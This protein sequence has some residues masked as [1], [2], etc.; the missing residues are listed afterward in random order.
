MANF[1][2]GFG[3]RNNG[4]QLRDIAI[5]SVVTDRASGTTVGA[6]PTRDVFNYRLVLVQG[7]SLDKCFQLGGDRSGL[8]PWV[9]HKGTHRAPTSIF[10][11]GILAQLACV[12]RCVCVVRI[13][14]EGLCFKCKTSVP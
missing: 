13:R 1:E 2:S 7:S 11:L 4:L 10:H 3:Y 14:F 6:I 9:V 12:S 5:S 8:S